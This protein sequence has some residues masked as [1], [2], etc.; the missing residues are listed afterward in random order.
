VIQDVKTVL[1]ARTVTSK[2][3]YIMTDRRR[4]TV[5]FDID[6]DTSVECTGLDGNESYAS[7]V[8][9]IFTEIEDALVNQDKKALKELNLRNFFVH[10]SASINKGSDIY[11]WGD[12]DAEEDTLHFS[13]MPLQDKKNYQV[14]RLSTDNDPSDRPTFLPIPISLTSELIQALKDVS[15]GDWEEILK[16]WEYKVGKSTYRLALESR[17][18]SN[19]AIYLHK[20]SVPKKHWDVHLFTASYPDDLIKWLTDLLEYKDEE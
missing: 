20:K 14:R 10:S 5:S 2:P 6:S 9:Y 13:Y 1:T 7:Y 4:V 12:G 17:G 3:R 11:V 18:E 15:E 8:P 19:V 16:E